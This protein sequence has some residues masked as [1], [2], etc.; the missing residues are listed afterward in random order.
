MNVAFGDHQ[1]T[2]WQAD[3]EARTI[4]ASAHKPVVYPGRWPGVEVALG[5]PADRQ[6]TRSRARRS[7]TGTTARS[8]TDPAEPS[9]VVGTDPPPIENLPNRSGDDPHSGPR[10]AAAEQQMV[11]DFLQ[12]NKKSQI[13]NTCKP[14]ACFAGGFLGP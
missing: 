8:A 6:A 10:N 7:S 3:V 1:V 4:G 2:T 13:T 9:A 12:P 11:S 14:L 5:N